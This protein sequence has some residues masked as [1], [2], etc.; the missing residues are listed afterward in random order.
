MFGF[1]IGALSLVGFVKVWRS[2][3]GHSRGPRHWMMR[4][5]Y[6][7]LDTTPGQEK[8]MAS[9]TEH[10][11][12]VMWQARDEFVRARTS[13]AQAFRGEHLDSAALDAAFEGQQKAI[14]E[15]K[16]AVREGMYQV[17]EAL[18]PEQRRHLADLLEFGPSRLHSGSRC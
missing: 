16:K 17:H 9:A 10:V 7:H 18:G 14:D 3:R 12:R 6:R 8:V 13:F 11:E 4:R 15:L 5:L 1:L 2:G